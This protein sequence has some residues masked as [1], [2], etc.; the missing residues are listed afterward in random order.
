M[1]ENGDWVSYIIYSNKE[2]MELKLAIVG[3]EN[4]NGNKALWFELIARSGELDFIIKRLVIG[5][6]LTPEKVL[7]QIVK[8]INKTRPDYSPALEIPINSSDSKADKTL[9]NFPCIDRIGEK[10]KYKFKKNEINAFSYKSEKPKSMIIYS[11]EL[12]FFGVVKAE[13]D[14]MKIEL[15]DYGRNAFSEINEKPIRLIENPA[16]TDTND[17]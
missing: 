4:Y 1:P 5:D 16:Q 7:R 17:H 13:S 3:E 14:N 11:K 8:I 12:P 15:V 2:R 9:Q 10:I 6:P